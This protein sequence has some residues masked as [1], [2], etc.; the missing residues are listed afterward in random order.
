MPVGRE[1]VEFNAYRV[2]YPSTIVECFH[3]LHLEEYSCTVEG[4]TEYNLDMH[5]HYDDLH[6]GEWRYGLFVFIK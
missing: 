6:N 3:D 1:K 5:K 4:K 2:F